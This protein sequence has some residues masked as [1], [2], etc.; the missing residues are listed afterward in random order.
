VTNTEF[1]ISIDRWAI[2]MLSDILRIPRVVLAQKL[3]QTGCSASHFYGFSDDRLPEM[4]KLL[5]VAH[6]HFRKRNL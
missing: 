1:E 3:S 5:S 4:V 6:E 2:E